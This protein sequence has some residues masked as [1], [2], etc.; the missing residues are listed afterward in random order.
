MLG[1]K[2]PKTASK[3]T[4]MSK[5]FQI[6]SLEICISYRFHGTSMFMHFN[7]IQY[8]MRHGAQCLL[9]GAQILLRSTTT[10]SNRASKCPQKLQNVSKS[11]ELLLVITLMFLRSSK[12]CPRRSEF[13]PIPSF[14]STVHARHS[15]K[16]LL[17]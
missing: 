5:F 13:A 16:F 10:R 7:E 12:V 2:N 4:P 15:F 6:F 3:Y 11:L 14:C 8:S 9:R 1:R 17:R